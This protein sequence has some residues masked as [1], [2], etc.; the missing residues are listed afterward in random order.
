MRALAIAIALIA[1]TCRAGTPEEA[2]ALWV[3]LAKTA[4]TSEVI[5]VPTPEPVSDIC[6]NCNGRGKVGDGTIMRICP[7]C[8]GTGKRVNSSIPISDGWPPKDSLAFAIPAKR[9]A[10]LEV[11]T[12][13]NCGPCERLQETYD[14][15]RTQGWIITEVQ[16]AEGVTP[17]SR[18]WVDGSAVTIVGYSGKKQFFRRMKSIIADLQD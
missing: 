4:E 14:E 18:V 8:D 2:K 13:D 15:L 12:R 11:F 6:E 5:P 7:V 10:E 16:A 17:R 9:H 3:L 1:I